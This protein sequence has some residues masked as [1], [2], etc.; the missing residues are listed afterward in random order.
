MP[1]LVV[2]RE[3]FCPPGGERKA[4]PRYQRSGFLSTFSPKGEAYLTKSQ[5]KTDFYI[6]FFNE[7]TVKL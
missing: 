7:F 4:K 1:S 2:P 6:N 5:A 3:L